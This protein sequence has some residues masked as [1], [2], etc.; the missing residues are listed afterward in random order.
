MIEYANASPQRTVYYQT[1][2]TNKSFLEMHYFLKDKGIKNNAFMLTLLD[3][4]L[5]GVDPFDPNLNS[6]MKQKV[7]RE[8][9]S[10]RKCS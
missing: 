9:I 3:N 6:M 8:C 5:A 2:T 4:D 10:K 7:F 1:S